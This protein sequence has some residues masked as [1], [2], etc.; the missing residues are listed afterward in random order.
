M[1]DHIFRVITVLSKNLV[2]GVKS[3]ILQGL[4]QLNIME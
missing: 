4:R 3:L 1:T 2:E